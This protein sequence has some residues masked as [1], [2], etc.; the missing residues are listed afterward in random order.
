MGKARYR[1]RD[2]LGR[3]KRKKHRS[4]GNGYEDCETLGYRARRKRKPES[5][6][7]HK[8]AGFDAYH[9]NYDESS[10]SNFSTYSVSSARTSNSNFDT[11]VNPVTLKRR[12]TNFLDRVSTLI[13]LDKARKRMRSRGST[14]ITSL[15]NFPTRKS[16]RKLNHEHFCRGSLEADLLVPCSDCGTKGS[17]Y[18][19][20]Y[21]LPKK[22]ARMRN[23]RRSSCS[24]IKTPHSRGRIKDVSSSLSYPT[25][26]NR[27][28]PSYAS[29]S[30]QMYPRMTKSESPRTR[31][32]FYNYD[33]KKSNTQRTYSATA[34]HLTQEQ[35][36]AGKN[37]HAPNCTC[38]ECLHQTACCDVMMGGSSSPNVEKSS[39]FKTI[40]SSSLSCSSSAR[41]ETASCFSRQHR[42]S[43][44]Y[45]SSP[46]IIRHEGG[47]RRIFDEAGIKTPSQLS[48]AVQ[49]PGSTIEDQINPRQRR[50][51]PLY[52]P[53]ETSSKE[54]SE[55]RK[56]LRKYL[57]KRDSGGCCCS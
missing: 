14:K 35:M 19:D 41:Q 42:R 24:A 21:L 28:I 10:E 33:K 56:R 25:Y 9:P 34:T 52:V 38:D 40:L 49:L 13:N 55:S 39:M 44:S 27:S 7:G 54:L 5:R 29:S 18:R 2:S 31:T 47:K 50:G 26:R 20:V 11:T 53:C 36:Q 45:K 6:T 1:L 4:Y 12:L 32:G 30:T 22:V 8:R 57:N 43:T 48:L 17:I 51:V 16:H 46:N 23:R 15:K 3:T 37:S